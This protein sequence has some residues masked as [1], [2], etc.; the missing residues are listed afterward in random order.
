MA[1]VHMIVV[2][3]PAEICNPVIKTPKI[4]IDIES[5]DAVNPT[6]FKSDGF[7][8]LDDRID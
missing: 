3:L 4:L 5:G 7:K 2:C 8:Y 6:P 1:L